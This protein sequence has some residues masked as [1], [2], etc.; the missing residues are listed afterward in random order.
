MQ[1]GELCN[2]D[3]MLLFCLLQKLCEICFPP[4]GIEPWIIRHGRITNVAASDYAFKKLQRGIGL[5]Q[6]CQMP[7]Q[8]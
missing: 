5:V 3:L 8:I 7:G 2:R 6:A 4:D 1:P